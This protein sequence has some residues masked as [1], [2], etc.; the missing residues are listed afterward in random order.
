MH[1]FRFK[2]GVVKRITSLWG[3]WALSLKILWT[4][5]ILSPTYFWCGDTTKW[6]QGETFLK[7]MLKAENYHTWCEIMFHGWG[8]MQPRKG[9]MRRVSETWRKLTRSFYII[10]N[11]FLELTISLKIRVAIGLV[12]LLNTEISSFFQDEVYLT[13]R[14]SRYWL[15][16][17]YKSKF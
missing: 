7:A 11:Y 13:F 2:T 16:F 1:F 4:N 3:I 17:R 9:T 8:I 12:F 6:W 15:N 5:S 10:L 14:E